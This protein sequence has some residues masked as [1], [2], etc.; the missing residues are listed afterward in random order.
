[1]TLSSSLATD[2]YCAVSYRSCRELVLRF[3][4]LKL[5]KYI[6]ALNNFSMR[7]SWITSLCSEDG[8]RL[9]R[10]D[11]LLVNPY[12]PRSESRRWVSMRA[13]LRSVRTRFG[14]LNVSCCAMTS[15][16]KGAA[17]ELCVNS[18]GWTNA[19]KPAMGWLI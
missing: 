7:T 19:P 2:D 15:A 18:P 17:G 1:M 13:T 12:K 11:T 4:C 8:A 9:D 6:G 10:S 16:P 5:S 3:G 14:S